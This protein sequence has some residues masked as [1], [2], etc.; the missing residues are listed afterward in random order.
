MAGG[1][2]W[3]ACTE[4]IKQSLQYIA[5]KL[6]AYCWKSWY[7]QAL[8]KRCLSKN[9][10][11]WV[12]TKLLGH[13]SNISRSSAETNLIYSLLFKVERLKIW[14]K[15][16]KYVE[17]NIDEGRYLEATQYVVSIN[18]LKFFQILY[19]KSK[20]TVSSAAPISECPPPFG[21]N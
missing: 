3:T 14:P 8:I 5:H 10:M 6:W 21:T 1:N 9:R 20:K 19:C 4:N 16:G 17:K 13:I 18:L 11:D 12:E 2:V 7:V 15:I